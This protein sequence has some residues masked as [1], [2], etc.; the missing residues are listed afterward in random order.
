MK[1]FIS[2]FIVLIMAGCKKETQDRVDIYMLKSYSLVSNS[3]T[4]PYTVSITNA[5]MEESP[6][7]KDDDIRSYGY[8]NREFSFRS[9]IAAGIKNFGPD[10]AFAVTVNNQPV[11]Y[12]KIHPAYLST[13]TIGLATI[14]PEFISQNSLKIEYMLIEGNTDLKVLDKRNDKR[15]LNAFVRSNRL[16]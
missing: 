10:K 14:A 15:I 6:L 5:V 4:S 16:K 9:D 12:G 11:Y 13:M 2:L 8:R 1:Y 3:S 7:V